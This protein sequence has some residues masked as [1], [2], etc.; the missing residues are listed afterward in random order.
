[1]SRWTQEL[2]EEA[3]RRYRA[4]ET[5]AQ[6]SRALK[7]E[8]EPF[9]RNAV[10][11]KLNRE[12]MMGTPPSHYARVKAEPVHKP[13][14]P[15]SKAPARITPPSRPSFGAIGLKAPAVKREGAGRNALHITE[16]KAVAGWK[17]PSH[18]EDVTLAK[19]L[20]QKRFGECSA[21]VSG[22]GAD[23]L[24]CCHPVDE[25]SPYCPTHRARFCVPPTKTANDLMRSLRRAA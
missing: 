20:A 10:V 25:G 11:G 3:K 6:I 23:T 15:P 4:G 1:M 21:P 16:A 17:A 14:A 2:I 18:V 22:E 13:A 7:P 5:S 9:T 12:G 24:F 8:G 19:P